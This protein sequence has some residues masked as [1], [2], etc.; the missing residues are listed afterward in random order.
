MQRF[1]VHISP[2]FCIYL[3]VILLVFPLK[4]V[5]CWYA[6]VFLHELCHI[7]ALLL[8][9]HRIN[10]I[11]FSIG[12]AYIHTQIR[13]VN[14][15]LICAVA[16][17]IGSALLVV[18]SRICPAIAFCGFVQCVFNLLPVYPLDGGRITR[19]ILEV[20]CNE[21]IAI[22]V[23]SWLERIVLLL[24]VMIAIYVAVV[25]ELGLLPIVGSLML[26]VKRRNI[27]CK[28]GLERVQ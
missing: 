24:I 11:R 23:A 21:H 12:G 1:N 6:A 16:G 10:E 4:W 13:N 19:C 22:T 5:V 2:A 3:C 20:C 14:K 9:G 18:F 28:Q 25:F 7:L 17:P 26:L 8:S 15:E 27:T